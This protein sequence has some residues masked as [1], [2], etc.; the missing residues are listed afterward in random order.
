VHHGYLDMI[1]SAHE[2][3]LTVVGDAVA[4]R[5][6]AVGQDGDALQ[7]RDVRVRIAVLEGAPVLG[8]E[9]DLLVDPGIERPAGPPDDRVLGHERITLP[10]ADRPYW[11]RRAPGVLQRVPLQPALPRYVDHGSRIAVAGQALVP[12]ARRRDRAP[13][14][15]ELVRVTVL[16][17]EG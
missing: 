7:L 4:V 5:L 13:R 17:V 9:V 10:V 11:R 14:P 12:L 2:D 1:L 6:V 8:L 16:A 3:E 15:A